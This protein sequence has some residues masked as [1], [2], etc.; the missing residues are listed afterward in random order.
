MPEQTA[1]TRA[2]LRSGPLGPAARTGLWLGPLLAILIAL[3]PLPAGLEREGLMIAGL[4]VLMAVW[5]ASEAVPIGITALLPL[6]IVPLTGILPLRA[7]AAPYADPVVLLLLGGFIVAI[8]IEKWDLHKRIALN[9]L[10]LSGARL[11]LLAAGFMVATALLS[12]WISNTATTLMMAPI[13]LSVAFAAGGGM[14]TAGALLLGIA[15]AASIGGLATP[16]G[17]PTNLI[18]IGWL[19]ENA[20]IELGFLDWMRFGLPAVAL[21]LP[22]AW[23]V[24]TRSIR[25]DDGAAGAAREVIL[26]ARRG[27][28]RMRAPEMRVAA[29]F[30]V[31]A[32]AWMSRSVLNTLPGLAGLTDMSIAIIGAILMFL[33]PNG[34]GNPDKGWALLSWEDARALPWEVVLLFG[35]G[36]SLAA[37]VQASGL[38]AWLGAELAGLSAIPAILFIALLVALIIFLTEIMS[39]VAAMTTFLPVLGALAA[40]TGADILALVIPTALA[41]SCAFMLPI[42]TGPN[43]VAFST[44]QLTI[45]R[46]ATTGFIINIAGIILITAMFSL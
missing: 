1:A 44:G 12:M 3:M 42:A 16:V 5:W 2:A 25:T 17:S 32:L 15:Y 41:A 35:G 28:G 43:A 40:A 9:V 6:A 24:I 45:A 34:S 8:G 31:V 7:I 39:N 21:L 37:A 19:R 29:V 27:L 10:A 30:A 13:A 14:K 38:A 22:V 20:G 46:M 33:L 4:L 23:F 26:E 18:A 11:K 36:L